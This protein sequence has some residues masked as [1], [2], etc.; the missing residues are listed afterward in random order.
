[1][2]VN[3]DP[4]D[5]LLLQCHVNSHIQLTVDIDDAMLYIHKV[6]YAGTVLLCVNKQQ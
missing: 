2:L 5:T 6:Y 3:N 1:M 4:L